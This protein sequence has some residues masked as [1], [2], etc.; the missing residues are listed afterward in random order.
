MP[1]VPQRKNHVH[2]VPDLSL[3]RA[4]WLVRGVHDVHGVPT[5]EVVD[6]GAVV[7]QAGRILEVGSYTALRSMYP[8]VPVVHHAAHMLLPGFVNGHHHVG[9][10]PL[11]SGAPDMALELWWAARLGTRSIDAYLDTLYSAFEMIAS[12]VTTVQHIHG[13]MSGGYEEV[14]TASTAILR[15]YR[16][17]GMR[18]SYCYAVREQ[19]RL[20]Y[21]D[22]GMFCERL[23]P[24]LAGPL[25]QVLTD[26]TMS[27]HDQMRLYAQLRDENRG[28]ALTRIQ[29]APANLHWMT[30]DGLVAM[31]ER[32]RADGVPAHMH[33]VETVYQQ[34][35]ARRRTGTTAVAHLDRLGVLGPWMT[36]GHGV[37]LTQEDIDRVAHAGACICHNCSSNFR[38]RSGVAPLNAFAAQG[39]TVALGLDEA[40]INDDRD[41]LQEMR[42]AL[43][44]HRTPG[45]EEAEVPNCAQVLRMATEH[46]ARTTPFGASIG[47]LDPGR[48]FDAV[49]I[50][51]D[52]AT[53]PYQD[54]DIPPLDAVL[55]RARSR[56]VDTVYIGGNVVYAQGRFTHV[57]RDSVMRQVE[58]QLTRARTPDE[59][60][61]RWLSKA[62][63]PHIKAFY[64]GYLPEQAAHRP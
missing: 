32:A 58:A 3:V 28:Q 45:M 49:A 42:L 55:Q 51:Y 9:V 27:F 44:V 15:A 10:T 4:R 52:T 43:R 17:I 5:S 64:D 53:Y 20:V 30:D 16:D 48:Q 46:G 6:D 35:Y 8:E 50:D 38:L 1:T 25:R 63:L 14:H 39:V 61:R 29:L 19:N 34:E 12:G 56:D 41:M 36:L 13:W 40:G 60:Q 62:V 18:A 21:E 47:R 23:P 54:P 26:Q 2:P 11:Q 59:L 31:A 22:D 24:E 7:H 37:W 57:D 33:L